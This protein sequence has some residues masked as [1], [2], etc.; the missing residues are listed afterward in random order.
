MIPVTSVMFGLLFLVISAPPSAVLRVR[1]VTTIKSTTARNS[2]RRAR[3]R[4]RAEVTEVDLAF[5]VDLIAVALRAGHPIPQALNS[6][7]QAAG[8][9]SGAGLIRVAAHLS[10]GAGWQQAWEQA[11]SALGL[12]PISAALEPAWISGAPAVN[13]LTHVRR[14]IRRDRAARDQVAAKKLGV[15]LIL[16]VAICYL[17]AFITLGLLP[18]V[19]VLVRQGINLL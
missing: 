13:L 4:S 14:R 11:P 8:G 6:V 10:L 9:R 17:P 19:I 18:V 1:A 16:P 3:L 5:L 2:K 15:R 7:G 12:E